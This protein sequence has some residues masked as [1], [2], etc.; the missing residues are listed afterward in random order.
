MVLEPTVFEVSS[1]GF[2]LSLSHIHMAVNIGRSLTRSKKGQ[3]SLDNKVIF[4]SAA[5][6]DSMDPLVSGGPR[7]VP[8]AVSGNF[9]LRSPRS[10][11]GREEGKYFLPL[12]L[13]LPW[14]SGHW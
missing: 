8:H 4:P 6:H 14:G 7:P 10:M 11:R 2:S 1:Q 13:L 9:S 3:C 5:T 12:T